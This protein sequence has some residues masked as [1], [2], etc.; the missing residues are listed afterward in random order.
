M[1]RSVCEDYGGR[2]GE[3]QRSK[4]VRE[5]R[6]HRAR[7]GAVGRSARYTCCDA[8]IGVATDAGTGTTREYSE[9]AGRTG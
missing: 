4:V 2:E 6:S 7:G 8:I 9:V 3:D 1:G 5:G